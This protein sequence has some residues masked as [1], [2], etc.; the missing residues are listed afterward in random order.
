MAEEATSYATVA[1]ADAYWQIYSTPAAWSALDEAQKQAALNVGRQYLDAIYGLR[2]IGTRATSDQIKDWPRVSAVDS[3]GYQLSDTTIPREVM[4]AN[5]ES[6]L[7]HV[8]E[9]DGLLPDTADRGRV[10]RE[11]VEVGPLVEDITYAG[12]KVLNKTFPKVE[13]ILSPLLSSG[14]RIYL[15]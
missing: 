6:A 3:D 13:R 10:M 2:W 15:G 5:I 11:R 9:P 12:G 14:S 1:E 8:T 4:D 7:R